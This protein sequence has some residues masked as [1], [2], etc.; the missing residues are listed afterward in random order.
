[1]QCEELKQRLHQLL[2]QRR[3][4]DADPRIVS[5]TQ[6]C[7]RCRDL[8]DAYHALVDGLDSMP[9]PESDH[10]VASRVL[11]ELETVRQHRQRRIRHRI[12]MLLTAAC[13][14]VAA[15]LSFT[16]ADRGRDNP[17]DSLA[18][19]WGDQSAKQRIVERLGAGGLPY[20]GTMDA[21]RQYLAIYQMTIDAMTALPEAVLGTAPGEQSAGAHAGPARWM[22]P[23]ANS[24]RPLTSSVSAAL[25]VLRRTLPGK[26][27][28]G[29]SPETT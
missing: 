21:E 28:N 20:D 18:N 12:G 29:K 14:L 5:H 15:G 17:G 24:I 9:M 8:L 3:H 16:G 10:G 22:E 6:R 23:M 13:L 27:H 19:G 4:P 2:D 25:G 26:P 11:A 7:G 1:M